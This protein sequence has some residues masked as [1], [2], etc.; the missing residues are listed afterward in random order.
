MAPAIAR[1]LKSLGR[2]EIEREVDEE[3]EFHVGL[4]QQEFIRQ[5]MSAEEA[6]NATE[7]RFGDIRRVRNECVAISKR[8]RPV[9]LVLKLMFALVF[10]SGVLV[11]VF[12]PEAHVDRV[13]H[14]L[15]AI[16]ALSYFLVYSRNFNPSFF[17]PRALL[18]KSAALRKSS[19]KDIRNDQRSP[20]ERL[21]SDD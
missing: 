21:L 12:S 11:A 16:G 8:Q 4:L 7:E 13:G 15:M 17:T 5:G 3:L 1:L 19:P 2:K 10:L 6:Q 18:L 20:V 14:L 9:V